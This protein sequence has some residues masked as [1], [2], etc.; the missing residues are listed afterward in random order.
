MSDLP[1]TYE[2]T[3]EHEAAVKA[4][5]RDPEFGWDIEDSDEECP[6]C[7]EFGDWEKGTAGDLLGNDA[8]SPTEAKCSHCGYHVTLSRG[9]TTVSP[10]SAAETMPSAAETLPV[11]AFGVGPGDIW[12]ALVQFT[13]NVDHDRFPSLCTVTGNTACGQTVPVVDL[14]MS[15]VEGPHPK[16]DKSLCDACR[17]AMDAP[18]ETLPSPTVAGWRRVTRPDGYKLWQREYPDGHIGE[19]HNDG[20]GHLEEVRHFKAFSV[21]KQDRDVSVAKIDAEWQ[22]RGGPEKVLVTRL[23]FDTMTD[24]RRKLAMCTGLLNRI[25]K[26]VPG[27]DTWHQAVD[28]A[29]DVLLN[30][31]DPWT[32]RPRGVATVYAGAPAATVSASDIVGPA[33]VTVEVMGEAPTISASDFDQAV[34]LAFQHGRGEVVK[35]IDGLGNVALAEFVLEIRLSAHKSSPGE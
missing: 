18:V 2:T 29:V 20:S 28:G 1:R 11:G 16:N 7:A 19:V 27:A 35:L 8:F 9:V 25:K 5:D 34:K 33:T 13:E 3:A 24:D 6:N 4:Y 31:A 15:P 30:P 32:G 10:A 26:A 21:G 12:H 17:K 14:T 22:R 23:V